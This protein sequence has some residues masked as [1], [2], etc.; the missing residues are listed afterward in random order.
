MVDY[1]KLPANR[2]LP[3]PVQVEEEQELREPSVDVVWNVYKE[4]GST[5]SFAVKVSIRLSLKS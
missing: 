2:E 3:D 1:Y 5:Q 4:K